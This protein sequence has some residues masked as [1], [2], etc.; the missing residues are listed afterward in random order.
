[1]NRSDPTPAPAT[2]DEE[3]FLA[4]FESL[5]QQVR[6]GQPI[7][8]EAICRQHP[9][10]AERLRGLVPTMTAMAELGGPSDVRPAELVARRLGDFE[11]LG[12]IGRGGMGLVYE[13]RQL[14]LDRRV[15][16]KVLPFASVLDN[17]QLARFKQEAQAAAQ[18]HHGHVV[19]V[20]SVG[21]ERGVHYYAM[22]LVDGVTL[23]D[24]IGSLDEHSSASVD[25]TGTTLA[26]LASLRTTCADDQQAETFR[27]AARLGH[28]AAEALDYAH[29]QGIVHRDI[30]PS[31]LLVQPD[32]HLWITDFG[33]ARSTGG[34]DL[35][36]TGA[37]VGT[38]RYMSPEQV[39][40]PRAQVDHR[41]DIYALGVT[42][43]ELVT[44][45]PALDEQA[46]ADLIRAIAQRHPPAPRRVNR[47]IPVDLE[48]IILKA[49][50]KEPS[51]RYA[52]AGQMAED[53]ARFVEDR[54]IAA[55]RAR[56]TE[57]ALG[58]SRRHPRTVWAMLATLTLVVV[59]LSVA[60]AL[61]FRAEGRAQANLRLA[62]QQRT[63]AVEHARDA[64][65]QRQR[66]EDNLREAQAAVDRLLG[67]VADDWAPHFPE[68]ETLRHA[69]LA[70]A[71]AVAETL[72]ANHDR[73]P[74]VRRLAASSFGRV[75]VIQQSLGQH[76]QAEASYRQAL[77][78]QRGL[79]E[80]FPLDTDSQ[81][82]SLLV[83][84][85]LATLL[86]ALG[87]TS[88]AETI[89]TQAISRGDRLVRLFPERDELRRV[90]AEN[91]LTRGKLQ[92][93]LGQLDEAAQA[94][95]A[96]LAL[97]SQL[98]RQGDQ[99]LETRRLLGSARY[100]LATV[101]AQQGNREQAASLC[102]Q[103]IDI[104]QLASPS[105]TTDRAFKAALADDYRLLG[106]LAGERGD[107][108]AAE[109][110]LR[111]SLQQTSWL[112]DQYPNAPTY[113]QSHARTLNR[114]AQQLATASDDRQATAESTWTAAV[115]Q[116]R[117]LLLRHPKVPQYREEL[118]ESL[119]G[120]AGFLAAFPERVH[121]AERLRRE[122]AAIRQSD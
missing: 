93:T 97:L 40:G 22:Q 5:S 47:A 35:T 21:S 68:A 113:Q 29:R 23:A 33:L 56:W 48:T 111:E 67:R 92:Q 19:P 112:V 16:L 102:R 85:R 71:L 7:D 77:A 15:A 10:H 62:K 90:L 106:Q 9:Q 58:W 55:R 39:E 100:G 27:A 83:A 96:S 42:I 8:V 25:L 28:Q 73:D 109:T 119:T 114:L 51:A 37:L 104:H 76:D 66:A 82:A 38:L 122:A 78:L 44:G 32:G 36:V 74:D 64:Q 14:S 98:D 88:D 43:Y 108:A 49:I 34:G 65:H 115:G 101:W 99:S 63:Q 72:L 110:A 117:V 89:N 13:A 120:L 4:L 103:A 12:E 81:L 69:L 107:W 91:R 94:Y 3:T 20:Y 54:P 30:K 24:V 2:A 116:Y 11:I 31:N 80:Q 75:G 60:M 41:A 50:A 84:N 95:Q 86:I 61:V 79:V 45:R 17:R 59:G 1:M 57:R 105:Q 121:D 52:T 118:A 70:D 46:Q 26:N 6:S 18:L 53:L 87:R